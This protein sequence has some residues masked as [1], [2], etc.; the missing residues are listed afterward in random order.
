M[1][2]GDMKE[3]ASD[4]GIEKRGGYGTMAGVTLAGGYGA[5]RAF[6][7]EAPVVAGRSVRVV[8]GVGALDQV[9]DEAR[10]LGGRALLVAGAHEDEAAERVG[11]GLGAGALAGRLRDVAQHVPVELAAAAVDRTR[12]VGADVLVAIGGGSATG[13]AK[14][15]ALKT[16]L[17]VLAVPTTYAGSEMTPI[18]GL[19]DA[20]GKRTGRDPA[21]LPRT[22]VYDP[23]LTVSLPS[24]VTAASGMNAI[25]HIVESLYAP[26][27]TP[28]HATRA[29]DGLRA[30]ATGLPVAVRRPGDLEARTQ[31]LYGAHLAG[32]A[33]GATT[34]G[35]HH[36]LAHVLGGAYRLPHAATHSALLPQVAAFNAAAAQ[37][38][39]RG[40]AS[41]VGSST[42][43]GVGAALFD[44]ARSLGAP[45]SLAELG[46]P[47]EALD[48]VVATVLAARV[49]NPRPIDATG[50]R[51]LLLKA[52]TG[53]RP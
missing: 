34:M 42:T 4:T 15:I 32:W 11:A 37:A 27:A 17:P 13:L 14:A 48:A 30:L 38:Q 51:D 21:V 49:P 31:A 35:L 18:W 9:A 36:K 12:E 29:E 41:A 1:G 22:V 7:R 2:L 28:E 46:L 39:L 53:T 6:V 45:T 25:A 8:F 50:L 26:D 16:G 52:H 47:L 10:R 5:G 33:L 20:D 43:S 24:E 44:L 19:S 40:A 23:A 3:K